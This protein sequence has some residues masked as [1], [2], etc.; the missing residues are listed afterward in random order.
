MTNTT[1][2][3]P[4]WVRGLLPYLGWLLTC[5]FAATLHAQSAG[6]GT[7]IG[8]IYNPATK[9]YV[10]SAEVRVEGTPLSTFTESDGSYT[11]LNVPA[12]EQTLA[13]SY[14]GYQPVTAKLNVTSGQTATRDFELISTAVTA[15]RA[16]D[17]VISL[18]EFVVSSEREGQSKAIQDQKRSMNITNI[19]ASD[20]FGDVAEGNVGE[21]LKYLPGVDLEYVEAD[22]R[23]PRIGGLDPE[24]TGVALDG[25]KLASAD[26][27]IQYNGTENNP[28]G[29]GSRSFGF[30]QVSINSIE[31]IEVSR[32]TSAD[33][34]A[35]SPAGTINMR[36]KRAFDSK[37]RRI[38]YQI[39]ALFNSEEFRASE[40]YGPDDNKNYKWKPGAMLEYS[41]V[42]FGN[43]LGIILNVSESNMYNEQFRVDH[44]YNTRTP[45]GTSTDTRPGVIRTLSFKSGPKFT[46]R[47]TTTLTA[48][49][50]FS[51]RL[52]AGI[53]A[54]YNY[55]DASFYN[56]Q[57]TFNTHA[58]NNNAASGK[59]STQG[60]GLTDITTTAPAGTN[61][62][63]ALGG[64]GATKL[65]D[66][67]TINGRFEYK[68]R[69]L[70]ID[71]AGGVSISTNDYE[72]LSRG[73]ARDAAVNNLNS[74]NFR[75]TRTSTQTA[76]WR[77]QQLDGP[78]WSD[79]ANFTNPRLSDEGRYAK[80]QVYNLALNAKYTT[81]WKLP[82][83]FK[84]GGKIQE[85]IW[86]YE[87]QGG[88]FNW[89]Y[90]G[91]GGN[92][93]NPATGAITTTGTYAA[94]PSRHIF[95]MGGTGGQFLGVT[96]GAPPTFP[97]R[98]AL[99]GLFYE[100]PEYFVNTGSTNATNWFEAY[101]ENSKD[102]KE[103]INSLYVMGNTKIKRLQIQTGLRWEQ[104]NVSS[105][106]HTPLPGSEVSAAGFPV[107]AGRATTIPGLIYQYRS[108]PRS[109]RSSTYD[110][111]F[112]SATLKYPVL[113]N[114][115][116]H[117]GYNKSI[118]R[119][120]INSLSGLWSYDESNFEVDVANPGLL[121][122]E[123]HKVHFQ[124]EHYFEPAGSFTA[125]VYQND[126]SSLRETI[127]FT[128]EE[129]GFG[130]DPVLS[131]YTFITQVSGQGSRRFRGLELNYNQQ[132]TFLPKPFNGLSAN[133]T[134]TRVYA[135][136][137]RNG[138]TPHKVTG[139][140]GYKFRRFNARVNAVW[141]DDT[142]WSNNQRFRRHKL[143][144]DVS[145]SYQLHRRVN[146][147]WQG[148]NITNES[149][150]VFEN[151]AAIGYPVLWREEK[152]GALWTFGVKGTF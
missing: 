101:V 67:K 2:H 135:N 5:A 152:Y 50:K 130:D 59:M 66:T 46:E 20:V 65:G 55:Y 108:Q 98:S 86:D 32:T 8:R 71:G 133:A 95:Q 54:I 120:S 16:G 33:M 139:G 93:L 60:N 103:Q 140:I 64:S 80:N 1:P 142:P 118:S 40:S 41:D 13:I 85:K 116:A 150:L 137:R 105:L 48:D 104:T 123:S 58:D 29:E 70:V 151:H 9:E 109:I 87:S 17:D 145:G 107:T 22:T 44:T 83:F 6:T 43:R 128:G 126:I 52:S 73:S 122:Q 125:S 35:D 57:L 134:Y 18:T 132:M 136:V 148:R 30:E 141:T 77:I 25:M 94:Y 37:G 63:V 76:D 15:P 14:T 100:H 49:Y 4:H 143:T 19:V 117:L 124:V 51:P 26:A 90:I 72:A 88:L 129:F 3:C 28:A 27:F 127:E 115:F 21:F 82:T 45:S 10:R 79:L 69:S 147:F 42:F 92:I 38:R 81:G 106:E 121:P 7:V 53:N 102:F 114:T 99:A 110:N 61:R 36:T 31:S 47:F 23:T 68:L 24:Y 131:Q 89:S 144:F 84:V 138:L 113:R 97:S 39:N 112:P 11:L 149:H 96:S 119:P 12:G 146:L 91:P 56:R 74:F 78:D 62:S 34:D 75:A 111:F